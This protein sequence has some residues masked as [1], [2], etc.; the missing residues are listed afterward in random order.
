MAGVASG[1]RYFEWPNIDTLSQLSESSR[2]DTVTFRGGTGLFAL[3]WQYTNSVRSPNF[4]QNLALGITA[5]TKGLKFPR[6][7]VPLVEF[8]VFNSG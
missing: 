4:G 7:F 3:N 1:E 2:I 5:Q 8:K 6:G